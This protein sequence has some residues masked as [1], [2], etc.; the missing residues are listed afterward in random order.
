MFSSI[1]LQCA[2]S[3]IIIEIIMMMIIM[4]QKKTGTSFL[5]DPQNAEKPFGLLLKYELDF[6]G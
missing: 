3:I 2:R 5:I 6:P 1:V 4:N